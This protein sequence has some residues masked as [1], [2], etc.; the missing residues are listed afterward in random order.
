MKRYWLIL[1][2]YCLAVGTLMAAE[3]RTE[4]EMKTIAQSQLQL[5]AVTRGESRALQLETILKAEA[6]PGS[7]GAAL[8]C[9]RHARRLPLVAFADDGPSGH[10]NPH[11]DP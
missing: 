8:Q 9:K 7:V 1:I 2:G 11:Q 10:G 6:R 3:H 5:G 4:R